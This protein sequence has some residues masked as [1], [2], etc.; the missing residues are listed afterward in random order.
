MHKQTGFTIVELLVVIAIIAILTTMA[1]VSYNS[2]KVKARDAQRVSDVGRI[3][4]ALE[5][6]YNKNNTYPL[7][8]AVV[9]GGVISDASTVYMTVVPT[10]PSPKTDGA[11]P[12]TAGYDYLYSQDNG[13]A[14]YHLVFCLGRD[15]DPYKAGPNVA[16]PKYVTS[17]SALPVEFI[18][19]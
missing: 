2:T 19:L 18:R 3:M 9:A 8:A 12:G 1:T 17:T 5:S 11:C 10:N 7:T 14:S 15:S 13:G 4:S 6:Y 16:T